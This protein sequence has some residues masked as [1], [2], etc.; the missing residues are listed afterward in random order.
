MP[1]GTNFTPLPL[2]AN[3]PSLRLR[4]LL[5]ESPLYP[6]PFLRHMIYCKRHPGTFRRMGALAAQT[7]SAHLSE[8]NILPHGVS[9]V[10][11]P[12]S[13]V[14][15]DSAPSIYLTEPVRSA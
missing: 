13:T 6:F 7:C 3:G 4:S 10:G 8:T 1:E 5:D 14:H 2:N 15:S 12:R 9:V 11:V